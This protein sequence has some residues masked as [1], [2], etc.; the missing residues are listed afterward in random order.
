MRR[1]A[2]GSLPRRWHRGQ[3][4]PSESAAH[5]TQQIVERR[6]VRHAGRELLTDPIEF[7]ECLKGLPVLDPFDLLIG[8]D[9][10]GDDLTTIEDLDRLSRLPELPEEIFRPLFEVLDAHS[11]HRGQPLT[12]NRADSWP[13][14]IT[15]PVGRY[16]SA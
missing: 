3:H 2:A 15:A 14:S 8:R 12:R 11:D 4:R 10:S 16:R 6:P 7:G 1:L 9:E 13:H 5:V